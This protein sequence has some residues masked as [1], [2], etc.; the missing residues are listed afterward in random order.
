MRV[1]YIEYSKYYLYGMLQNR[2]DP[3]GNIIITKARG[4]LMGNRGQLHGATKSILR[5]FKL[6]AWITCLLEFKGWHRPVMAPNQYTELFFLDEA[7]AF[8]AGHRPCF[9]CR[10]ADYNRFKTAWLT[11][12]PEYEF[13]Q[14]TSINEIDLIMHRER[15]DDGRKVTFEADINTLPDGVFILIGDKPYLKADNQVYGWTAFGYDTDT[16][17]NHLSTVTVLTPKCTVNAFKAGYVPIYSL[18]DNA[19]V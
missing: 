8:A 13:T 15:F 12:N 2:V 17:L 1:G 11:G 9:E 5:P 10:R 3:K 7:T 4:T 16:L 6:R 18:S 14:K 19:T